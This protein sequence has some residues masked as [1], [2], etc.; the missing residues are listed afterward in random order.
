VSALLAR[1]V[2]AYTCGGPVDAIGVSPSGLVTARSAGAGLS[3]VYLCAIGITTNGVS[4]DAC[5]GIVSVL[6]AAKETGTSVIWWFD[7]SLACG[8][9]P[10]SA[11]LSGWHA[12]LLNTAGAVAQRVVRAMSTF[13]THGMSLLRWRLLIVP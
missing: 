5:K 12:A 4:S 6:V 8:T 10:S 1:S 7:D 13:A 11:W 2:W 9:H 3:S